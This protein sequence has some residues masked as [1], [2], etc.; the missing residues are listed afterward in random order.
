MRAEAV[1][2]NM[3]DPSI[4]LIWGLKEGL[5]SLKISCSISFTR[6][7]THPIRHLTWKKLFNKSGS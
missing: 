7:S 4:K 5:V 6:R 2:T 1:T 3:E